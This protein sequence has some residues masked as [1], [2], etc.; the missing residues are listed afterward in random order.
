[1]RQKAHFVFCSLFLLLLCE[2]TF[3]PAR[4]HERVGNFQKLSS[5]ASTIEVTQ[6]PGDVVRVNTRVVFVD[7]LVKDKRTGQPIRELAREDFQVLVDG[8]Q[9]TI[10]YFSREGD[11]LRPLAVIICLNLDLPLGAI[12]YLE[13]SE[14]QSS[15]AALARLSPKDEVAVML[16]RSGAGD[17]PEML[18]GLTRDRGKVIAALRSLGSF[19]QTRD[20]GPVA[21]MDEA[22]EQAAQVAAKERPD[23]QT[24]LLYISNGLNTFD[25]SDFL[26]RDNAAVKLIRNNIIFS[27]LTF[28]MAKLAATLAPI[29]NQSLRLF[30]A[31][32]TGSA[33]YFSK[34][35]GGAEVR[36]HRPEDFVAGLEQIT[37]DLSSRYSL[38]FTLGEDERDDGRM[39]KLEVKVKARDPQGKERKLVVSSRRGYYMPKTVT[40]PVVK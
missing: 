26:L 38:G 40:T 30:G 27:A 2:L 23:S 21:V 25:T 35:T 34:Q 14:I 33:G 9:R 13:R 29:F 7:T 28:D 36:I 17:M 31:S 3:L 16:I 37:N 24:V 10:S 8:K 18:T 11:L 12:R 15:L 19:A 20:D 39:H 1:M 6:E 5:Q 22:I 4:S 32:L